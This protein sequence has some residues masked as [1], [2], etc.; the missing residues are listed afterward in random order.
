LASTAFVTLLSLDAPPRNASV[1]IHDGEMS[2]RFETKG[3]R[4]AIEYTV[5][6]TLKEL[7]P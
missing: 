5:G 2:I 3:E 1:D 6:E 4:V 7:S